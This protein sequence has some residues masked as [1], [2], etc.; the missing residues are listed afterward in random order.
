M[1]I[2]EFP[3]F[4]PLE[5]KDKEIISGVF[6]SINPVI[7]EFT[8][9]NLFI[10][11]HSYRF[12]VSALDSTLLILACPEPGKHFFMP[13]AG[14]NV[15]PEILETMFSFMTGQKWSP[16]IRRAPRE[17][18]DKPGIRDDNRYCFTPARDDFDYVYRTRDLIELRGKKL[19][20]K[21]NHLNYFLKNYDFV[22]E[23]LSDK[24]VQMCVEMQE[25]WCNLK[26][27][28]G[29]PD[30]SSEDFAVFEALYH[31]KDLDFTGGVILIDGKVEAFSLGEKLNHNTAVVHVEK[32]NPKI[33]GLY[34]AINQLCCK[35]LW[36]D[37]EYVNR[38]QDLGQ[39]GLRQAKLSYDP[40]FLV[41]KYTITPVEKC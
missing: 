23:P 22:F 16:V 4:R 1:P 28:A 5:L 9:T 29:D 34:P 30:L 19:R 20:K 26:D 35:H 36:A 7:S 41:E 31:W 32:A 38:E 2:P 13:P 33:R 8:F 40:C 10:W 24:T 14:E 12:Q 15:S 21:K 18:I 3:N 6:R 37:C 11:R 17:L 27:C 39:E 25:E